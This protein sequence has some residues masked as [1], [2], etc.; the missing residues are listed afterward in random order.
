MTAAYW[1]HNWSK[2][3]HLHESPPRQEGHPDEYWW[4]LYCDSPDSPSGL[5]NKL[6]CNVKPVT[7]FTL[8]KPCHNKF[9]T[10]K[11]LLEASIPATLT[12][13]WNWNRFIWLCFLPVKGVNWC[14][15]LSQLISCSR[16]VAS[17]IHRNIQDYWNFYYELE[18]CRYYTYYILQSSSY[19]C[20]SSYSRSSRWEHIRN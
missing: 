9:M 1:Y 7:G 3:H 11:T 8:Q 2:A 15:C 6:F 5:N 19:E 18:M 4:H 20:I 12:G 17:Y 14:L 10:S 16:E 13:R